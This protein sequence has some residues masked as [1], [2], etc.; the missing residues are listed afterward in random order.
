MSMD[1][2]RP[3][4]LACGRIRREKNVDIKCKKARVAVID[5]TQRDGE[6]MGVQR[7]LLCWT[8]QLWNEP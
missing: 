1:A 6:D 5:R 7:E 4:L 2:T 8:A 3:L